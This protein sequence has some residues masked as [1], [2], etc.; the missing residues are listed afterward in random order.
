VAAGRLPKPKQESPWSSLD[1]EEAAVAYKLSDASIELLSHAASPEGAAVS[2]TSPL[3]NR[4]VSAGFVEVELV[5]QHCRTWRARITLTGL[6]AT[7]HW[8]RSRL[9]TI[10]RA[11]AP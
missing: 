2:M 9:L 5:G 8:A 10:G 6:R 7:G 11:K 1:P 3:M 4:L